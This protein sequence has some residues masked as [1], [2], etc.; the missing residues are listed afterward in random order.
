M[1]LPVWLFE[2]AMLVVIALGFDIAD[3]FDTNAEFLA[4]ILLFTAVANLAG[5]VPSVSGGIGPF[6]FFGAATLVGTGVAEAEAAT[7]VLTAHVALLV[8]VSILGV[9]V[10]VLDGTSL[11]SLVKRA[12]SGPA[13]LE[14]DSASSAPESVA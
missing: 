7:Y 2:A 10:L 14:V 1:S 5:V 9:I 3:S 8:P 13:G 4:A 11:R 6:E 12:E